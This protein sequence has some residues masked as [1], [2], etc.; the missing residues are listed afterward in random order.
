MSNTTVGVKDSGT[1]LSS[2]APLASP[3]IHR[4]SWTA[5]AINLTGL[6]NDT[7]AE[8]SQYS[9]DPVGGHAE[10]K[11]N[12]GAL[13]GRSTSMT[14]PD[15]IRNLQILARRL[16]QSAS[17]IGSSTNAF[18]GPITGTTSLS[19]GTQQTTQG[20]I[21]SDTHRVRAYVMTFNC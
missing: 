20:S 5:A 6:L 21:V 15:H 12:D 16:D 2:L 11:M 4:N 10:W 9:S 1:L 7:G 13:E 3:D 14:P 17:L 18:T 8:G 19:L